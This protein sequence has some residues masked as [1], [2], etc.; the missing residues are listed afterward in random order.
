MTKTDHRLLTGPFNPSI[1]LVTVIR[2]FLA[3][4]DNPESL[5]EGNTLAELWKNEESNYTSWKMINDSLEDD[6]ERGKDWSWNTG[7]YLYRNKLVR[8]ICT[9]KIAIRQINHTLHWCEDVA[10]L[11]DVIPKKLNLP[12]HVIDLADNILLFSDVQNRAQ[13]GGFSSEQ[14]NEAIYGKLACKIGSNILPSGNNLG[15]RLLDGMLRRV[16]EQAPVVILEHNSRNTTAPTSHSTPTQ[17]SQQIKYEQL[18]MK[19]GLPGSHDSDIKNFP[20][21]QRTFGR[22]SSGLKELL[23][24]QREN[25]QRVQ[26]LSSPPDPFQSSLRVA[27]FKSPHIHFQYHPERFRLPERKTSLFASPFSTTTSSWMGNMNLNLSFHSPQ[28]SPS[29]GFDPW[30]QKQGKG[31]LMESLNLDVGRSWDYHYPYLPTWD[32]SALSSDFSV[33]FQPSYNSVDR[34]GGW[35]WEI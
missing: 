8:D 11:G 2:Q 30:R 10:H 5:T 3:W 12:L 16:T 9:M 27:D 25:D 15:G 20:Q 6:R 34:F 35:R 17:V 33:R 18:V 21:F 19:F 32:A 14:I 26:Q 23:S 31:W 28:H 29:G 22:V 4:R 13:A 7:F 1:S 24:E